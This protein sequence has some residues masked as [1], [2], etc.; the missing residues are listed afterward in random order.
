MSLR[1]CCC[2][3]GLEAAAASPGIAH[4]AA[5]HLAGIP[6]RS[7]I[8]SRP[9]QQPAADPAA[10]APHQAASQ[11]ATDV[12]YIV[13]MLAEM[14]WGRVM[15]EARLQA[16]HYQALLDAFLCP[17]LGLTDSPEDLRQA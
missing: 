4:L 7:P 13:K 8:G 6:T 2:R 15:E 12:A 14:C 9:T 3:V 16:H 17:C 5:Q 10:D 1:C 11:H